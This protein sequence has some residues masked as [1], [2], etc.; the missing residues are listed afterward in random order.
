[1][2]FKVHYDSAE[3]ILYLAQKGIAAESAEL[4]PGVTIELDQNGDPIGV[5]IMDASRILQPVIAPLSENSQK[6]RATPS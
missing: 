3:D 2:S 4:C 5:E 1:M 6:P